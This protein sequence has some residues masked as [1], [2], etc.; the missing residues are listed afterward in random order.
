MA[1]KSLWLIADGL[2]SKSERLNL[3]PLA[4][5][6]SSPLAIRYRLFSLDER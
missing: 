5:G 3:V 1:L 2:C 4:I 6:S